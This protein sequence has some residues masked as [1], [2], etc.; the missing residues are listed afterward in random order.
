MILVY[1]DMD[2]VIKTRVGSITKQK[3]Q[4]ML[5]LIPPAFLYN[6]VKKSKVMFIFA[7][8]VTWSDQET[9]NIW[10]P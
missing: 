5:G 7:V 10:F 6:S 4:Q 2:D 8:D 1:D 3:V 9:D